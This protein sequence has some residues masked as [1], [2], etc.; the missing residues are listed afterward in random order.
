MPTPATVETL[1]D[2]CVLRASGADNV[3]FLQAQLTNDIAALAANSTCKAAWCD[4]KGRVLVLFQ[5]CRRGQDVLLVAPRHVID[6]HLK[7]L[8]MFV[9]RAKVSL[10]VDE[11]LTV[12][13]VS[14]AEATDWLRQHV[15]SSGSDAEVI[16]HGAA[17]I[18]R[19]QGES[20]WYVI[21]NQA[22]A[23][24]FLASAGSLA[25]TGPSDMWRA[26]AIDAGEPAVFAATS[27]EFVP[28]MLNLE[29]LDGV[30]FDKG[31]Y[32]GQEIVARTQYLGRI[33]R[34][35]FA[36]RVSGDQ[37][38]EPGTPILGV[39][40]KNVGQVVSAAAPSTTSAPGSML[41]VLRVEAFEA[42]ELSLAD[43]GQL[44]RA[45]LPYEIPLANGDATG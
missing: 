45:Q 17:G 24:Q 22:A 42:G 39:D 11:D 8:R 5:V 15:G 9:M 44:S 38:P 34:R 32:P 7:R 1:D 19:L 30:S 2:L 4:P 21:T 12:M 23:S 31:C 43:G 3:R 35:M 28:Q 16:W 10:E 6:Q 36:L 14:G 40:A 18:I 25:C 27:G 37:A 20:R 29:L 41:A 26:S 13:G 33:K